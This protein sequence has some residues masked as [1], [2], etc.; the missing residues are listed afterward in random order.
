[1]NAATLPKT[2]TSRKK[3]V[4]RGHGSGRGKTAGRGTKGQKAR[5]KIPL[6]FEGG[7]LPLMKRLPFRRGK[8]KNRVF[9]KKPVVLNVRALNLLPKASIVSVETLMKH[10]LVDKQDAALYGVKILGDGELLLPLTVVLPTSKQAA[11]KIEKA[12]GT[13][14]E[15]EKT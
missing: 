3:R 15:K 11:R 10:H 6:S 4:G 13:V 12:G 8:G 1:M 14:A 7:A 5:G 9:A 2:V